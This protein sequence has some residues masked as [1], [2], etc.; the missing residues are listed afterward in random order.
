M[1]GIPFADQ[2]IAFIHHSDVKGRVEEGEDDGCWSA[3]SEENISLPPPPPPRILFA[4][5]RRW[6]LD[7]KRQSHQLTYVSD[8]DEADVPGRHL[9]L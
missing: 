3:F 2:S 8:S 4:W 7:L 1:A 5:A 6:K 9:G